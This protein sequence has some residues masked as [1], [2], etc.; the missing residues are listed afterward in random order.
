MVGTAG[1]T[2]AHEGDDRAAVVEC[3]GSP[4][5]RG[6]AHGEQLRERI[7]FGLERLRAEIVEDRATSGDPEA[8][9]RDWLAETTHLSAIEL[10]TPA[11][12]DE[13]R[14][15]AE[16]SDQPFEQILAFNL[17]DEMWAAIED[18]ERDP[19]A[20]ERD[21]P[22]PGCSAMAVLNGANGAPL[23]AQTM[24]LGS[25]S[26]GTQAVLRVRER[27]GREVIVVTRA[28][29]VGLMG[30]ND[31]G[32]G[33][34]VNALTLLAHNRDGLPV[35]FV[36]RGILERRTLAEA[37]AFVRG[38][39]HASGQA[40]H[41]GS[42]EGIGSYE[43]S[44][45]GAVAYADGEPRFAHTNHP[46]ATMDIASGV[47]EWPETARSGERLTFLREHIDEVDSAAD[48]ERLL[49]DRSAPICF[50]GDD[51]TRSVTVAAISMELTAPPQ[52]RVAIGP[53]TETSAFA[54]VAF[55]SSN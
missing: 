50:T 22:L 31:A 44:S 38:V 37:T 6:R 55:A 29:M 1:T 12:A 3:D 30:A 9:L 4:R 46:L 14:G 19:E 16:G 36:V 49:T 18:R 27:D 2:R 39:P 26:E 54:P 35:A 52:V 15:I 42:P 53:P 8:F 33:V 40:Y 7:A 21:H 23:L 11:L 45:G 10:H 32:V 13:L 25:H 51:P 17:M 28:G 5:E 43:C 20:F 34:V 48:C 24:D 41:I 47:V